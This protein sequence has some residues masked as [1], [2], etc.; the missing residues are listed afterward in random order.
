MREILDSVDIQ[1]RKLMTYSPQVV[2]IHT[3][4]AERYHKRFAG[5]LFPSIAL[6]CRVEPSAHCVSNKV[7][8]GMFRHYPD[9][10]VSN[11]S[12]KSRPRCPLGIELST[13]GRPFMAV[14]ESRIP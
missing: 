10:R 4:N 13:K 6:I 9:S 7:C 5:K 12:G 14:S 1:H 11:T 8:K 3:V 2:S